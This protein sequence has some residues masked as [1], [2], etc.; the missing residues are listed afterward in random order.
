MKTTKR[1]SRY[2]NWMSD[3][4]KIGRESHRIYL[5][6]KFTWRA[7][8]RDLTPRQYIDSLGS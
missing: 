1:A 3:L 8:C 5:R 7:F 2:I 4:N 6:S